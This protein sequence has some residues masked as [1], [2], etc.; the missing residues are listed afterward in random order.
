LGDVFDRGKGHVTLYAQNLDAGYSAPGLTTPRKTDNFGGSFRMPVTERLNVRAK[1]DSKVQEQGLEV[2]AREID[3]DYRLSERWDLSVG[4]RQDRRQDGSAIVPLTQEQGERTDAVVQVAYDSTGKWRAYAFAQDTLS[5]TGDRQDNARMGSGGSYRVTDKFRVDMEL[6]DGDLGAGGRL[7]TNYLHSDHT[8]L[9]VNYALENER[10]DDGLHGRGGTLVSGVK[11]RLS[12][13]SSVYLEERYQDTDSATGLTHATGVNL[14]PNDRWNFGANTEIGR[15]TDRQTNA[16]TQRT[17]GGIRVG[18]GLRSLQLSSGVEYRMDEAE[19]PDAS[20]AERLTWLFRNNFKF[21]LNEDWRVL[22]KVNHALSDS[23]LG[24]FHDGGY[25]E[26][27]IGYGYRPVRNDRLNALAKYTYFYN[28]PTTDQVTP[29]NALAQFV[30]KSHIAALD[31]SF[32][33]TSRWSIGGKYA[34]RQGQ[35]SL[36]RENPQF[37][38]NRAQLVILRTDWRFRQHWETLVEVRM[39]EMPDL[40]ERRGGALTAVYRHVTEHLKIG[41]G[42]NFTDFS[43]DLTDLSY[44]HQGA[45][46][47]VVGTL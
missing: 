2:E 7:G 4:A 39:L 28:I 19:Q 46:I 16:E 41:A 18:Y 17:A 10:T 14:A 33:L 11:R 35:V 1:A 44:T 3:V 45:F 40:D 22:G 12:D 23:S 36:S 20:K 34:Y 25:T 6:S 31:V 8:N 27:V 42:Y 37:F 26:A 32:D 43:E 29:Q 24:Q 47:N 21:Q 13:S 15:F 5:A 30:Q 9:Y 38:D